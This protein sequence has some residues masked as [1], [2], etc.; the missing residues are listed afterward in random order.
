MW[1]DYHPSIPNKQREEFIRHDKKA[2]A[3]ISGEISK[4]FSFY[5]TFAASIYKPNSKWGK[6]A[7]YI[8]SNPVYEE[9]RIGTNHNCDP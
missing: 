6:K 2:F 3:I 8:D 4:N 1:A 7:D 5:F 9:M